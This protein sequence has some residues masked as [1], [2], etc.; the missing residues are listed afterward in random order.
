MWKID[1]TKTAVKDYGNTRKSY[2]SKTIDNLIEI[3]KTNPF[4]NP[5]PYKKM[6]PPTAE[7]YSRRINSQHRLYY[8][9]YK[10]EKIVKIIRMW[11]HYE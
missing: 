1:M 5:P 2:Y 9:V 3:L 6:E 7:T 10:E 4:Q 8:R 11:T